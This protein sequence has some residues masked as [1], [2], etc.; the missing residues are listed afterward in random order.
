MQKKLCMTAATKQIRFQ[1]LSEAVNA[2]SVTQ[3]SRAPLFE[4]TSPALVTTSRTSHAV[5]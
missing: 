3:L 4:V 1:L 5:T 2:V